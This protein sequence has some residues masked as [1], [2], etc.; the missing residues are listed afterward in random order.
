VSDSADPIRIVHFADLHIGMENYGRMDAET[1]LNGRVAD[2][3]ERL[4]QIV[5]H[6]IEHDA[7]LVL[8]AGDAFRTRSPS[9][10]HQR[11]FAQR[12][13]TLSDAG[14]PVVIL[15]GNHDVPVMSQRASSVEIFGTLGVPHVTV[16]DAPAVHRVTTKRGDVQVL[17]MPYP[18]RQRL[19]SR[20]QFRRMTQDEL[21]RAVTEV[22]VE[23]LN[24]LATSLDAD[25]PAVLLGHFSV[26]GAHWGSE[27]SIMVGRDVALPVSALIDPRWQYVALGHIH[28]HQD[29]NPEGAPPVVY[30]GSVE[31]VDFGEERQ[32]KGFCWVELS[33]EGASWRYIRLPARRFLT[34]RVDVREADD[35]LARIEQQITQHELVG[36]VVR[37]VVQMTPEQ[38]PGIRDADLTPLLA[39]AFYAQI[40]REVDRTARDRLEGLEPDA[41]TPVHLLRRYLLAKG[42]SEEALAPYVEAAE[43]LFA[44]EEEQDPEL[45]GG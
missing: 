24:S 17:T 43:A 14:L 31:R 23:T 36:A 9:T 1:G 19:L 8:F 33:V 20:E 41:M 34:V 28:Q 10:T 15:V 38:E 3:L 12:I 4:D 26:D 16:A 42:R 25:C 29:L 2:F 45:E 35:P 27:R 39:G 22:L 37:L 21:D 18:V 11:E 13:R 5:A 7:D 44:A 32:P 6:A 30:A 40:N